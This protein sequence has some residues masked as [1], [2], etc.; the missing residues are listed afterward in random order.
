[1]ASS[2]TYPKLPRREALEAEM[3]SKAGDI[4]RQENARYDAGAGVATSA[5]NASQ[6]TLGQ[7]IDPDLLFSKA[8]DAI[9]ARGVEAMNRTRS[10]LGARGLNPNSGAASGMLERLAF[11][12]G[13]AVVGATRDVEL[14]NQKQRQTSAAIGF[15]NAMNLASYLNSPVSGIEYENTQNLYEG[16]LALHGIESA[17]NSNAKA[18]KSNILGGLIG[19]GT[20]VLGGL[21]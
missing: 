19:A 1:M 9:G 16:Q 6:K 21:L 13:N 3:T 14:E 18:N 20:S 11:Q 8:T 10:S 4:A 2:V 17:K 15:Q 7:L 5:Y 12:T